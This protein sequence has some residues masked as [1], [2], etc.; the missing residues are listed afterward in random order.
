MP[1]KVVIPECELFDQ[2]TSEFTNIKRTTLIMEHSLISI[3]KWESN[4][5]VPFIEGSNPKSK[6]KTDAMIMD[7]YRCMVISPKEVDPNVFRALPRSEMVRINEYIEKQQTASSV[8]VKQ[9]ERGS[10]EQVTSELIYFWMIHYGIPESFD[11]WHLSRL[12]MLIRICQRKGAP[13]DKKGSTAERSLEYQRIS[14][15]RR[16]AAEQARRKP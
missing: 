2:A 11:K 9:N 16:K 5:C 14:A 6:E 15:Q 4:W 10:N 12:L 13:P 3:S 7:Y 8:P 1:I